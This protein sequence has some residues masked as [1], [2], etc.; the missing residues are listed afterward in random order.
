MPIRTTAAQFDPK[1]ANFQRAP[2][3]IFPAATTFQYE[4]RGHGYAPH[5]LQD[6]RPV[7]PARYFPLK[8]RCARDF[9]RHPRPRAHEADKRPTAARFEAV[10]ISVHAL[11][12][13]LLELAFPASERHF[14]PHVVRIHPHAL[15]FQPSALSIR[16]HLRLLASYELGLAP[17]VTLFLPHAI[18][19]HFHYR[20]KRTHDAPILASF[21]TK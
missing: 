11:A 18:S 8:Q 15:A 14:L 19:I 10:S 3:L 17:H 9:A 13:R 2:K 5:P 20:A 16:S 1:I 7:V 6:A 12:I 21:P 4:G